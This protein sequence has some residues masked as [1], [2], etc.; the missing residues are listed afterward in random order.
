MT[1]K[2]NE[3]SS[4][5][6]MGLTGLTQSISNYLGSYCPSLWGGRTML[7]IEKGEGLLVK[8]ALTQTL[9][10]QSNPIDSKEP[11]SLKNRGE[12]VPMGRN[13][14]KTELSFQ[15]LI[16]PQLS[17]KKEKPLSEVI[18]TD[19]DFG[20][21]AIQPFTPTWLADYPQIVEH[22]DSEHLLHVKGLDQQG[23][24]LTWHT[25]KFTTD[26]NPQLNPEAK[27]MGAERGGIQMKMGY[28]IIPKDK[29]NE[30]AAP[31][32]SPAIYKELKV[33]GEQT[34]S[35]RFFVHPEAYEH[36]RSLH[37][38]SALRYVSPEA[39]EYMATP[40]SS[41]R[42]LAIR[43]VKEDSEGVMRPA[44]ESI[45]FVV[46]V[47]VGGSVLGSDRWLS[48]NEIERSVQC[49]RAFDNMDNKNF[50]GAKR[51][52]HEASELLIFPESL[53][54]SLK[55]IENYPPKESSN[56]ASKAS[57][58]IIREFPK[59][60]LEGK[61]KII[62]LGSLMSCEKTKEA[63]AEICQ[64]SNKMGEYSQLPLIYQVMAATI[65]AGK[66]DSPEDFVRRYLIE[67]YVDAIEAVTFQ[68]GMT[69]EPHS[70]NLC[71][72]LSN[73]LIP[74]GFAYRDHGGIW[75]D[76]AT[77]GLQ[78]KTM[79]PFHRE[80]GDGNA[81]F[82][83]KGAI[84]KGYIGSYS[85]FY[86]YQVFVKMLNTI[87]TLP[88][89]SKDDI[90]PEFS[91][92]PYQIGGKKFPERNI[93]V[94]VADQ[95]KGNTQNVN[96]VALKHLQRLSL[97]V[98][99]SQK[100]LQLLDEYYMDKLSSYFDMQKVGLE[101]DKGAM[102]ASEGGSGFEEEMLRHK[103][104]L[105]K[106]KFNKISP[107]S[108][109]LELRQIPAAVL[110]DLYK[111]AITSFDR[112]DMETLGIVKCILTEQGICFVDKSKEIVAFSPYSTFEERIKVEASII[113]L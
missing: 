109:K 85:W 1:Y 75:V 34:E 35:Y 31:S 47:G 41:Y 46:K 69:L 54:I 94:Y 74:Q 104:F 56:S 58:M 52:G 38:D 9:L 23:R 97:T 100:A 95:L 77:R 110:K 30:I 48:T 96:Q 15:S 98:E 44:E 33:E 112:Q 81:L 107:D 76:I 113:K 71:M 21:V 65:Q 105:G 93:N 78:G 39:S 90:M 28:F 63:C 108:T 82:K 10:K 87:T 49:Q 16:N 103:G 18:K 27:F 43:K 91:G 22:L 20:V 72:V 50:N 84:S 14:E 3:T 45:P 86:R 57:G 7:P 42:S 36:F 73:D 37:N 19:K 61:N 60:L 11:V 59:P 79:E 111:N 53:G 5:L 66:A 80:P 51:R 32:L 29:L 106:Y 92:A 4:C 101:L 83:T 13:S 89:G 25:E 70:Q 55:D 62:N 2:T 8:P 102:P 26:M 99:Q 67:G 68:E 64:L 6:M 17:I 24:G 12:G 88:K 40:T